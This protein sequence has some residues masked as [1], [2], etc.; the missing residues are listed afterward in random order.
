MRNTYLWLLQLATGVLIVVLLGIHMISIHLNDILGFLGVDANEPVSWA[1]MIGRAEQGLW[2][3]L[4]IALL[5]VGLYHGIYGLRGIILEATSSARTGR[6]ITWVMIV[7]GSITF[8]GG[9]YVL[10][11]ML[12]N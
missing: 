7:I 5:A 11:S 4:Y 3:S 10:I 12:S 2:A 9:A 8:I 1:S 6:I